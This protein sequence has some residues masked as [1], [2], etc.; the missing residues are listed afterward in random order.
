MDT[1]L[2]TT[3][4]TA[5]EFVE[6]YGEPG[7]EK[8]ILENDYE[9][10]ISSASAIF[11]PS[12]RIV[13]APMTVLYKDN[14]GEFEADWCGTAIFTFDGALDLVLQMIEQ[15]P[16]E[17]TLKNAK[18]LPEATAEAVI[19]NLN[20]MEFAKTVEMQEMEVTA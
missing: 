10:I 5:T 6:Q 2:R 18:L 1:Y 4:G 15:D 14:S 16:I 11:I 20:E 8:I 13:V 3:F 12:K 9:Q 7:E 19:V 17:I